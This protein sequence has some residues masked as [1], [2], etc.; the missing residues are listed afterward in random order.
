MPLATRANIYP[1]G[2]LSFRLYAIVNSCGIV[3]IWKII[4]SDISM[5][6]FRYK[7]FTSMQMYRY[8][9]SDMTLFTCNFIVVKSDMGVIN[10][11][12]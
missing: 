7:Y 6:I 10:S 1:L 5:Q 2:T 12:G 11:T 9:M 4:Y 3:D 8:L